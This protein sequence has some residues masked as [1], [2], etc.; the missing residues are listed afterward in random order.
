VIDFSN[1][2]TGNYQLLIQTDSNILSRKIEKL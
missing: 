2:S 1:L